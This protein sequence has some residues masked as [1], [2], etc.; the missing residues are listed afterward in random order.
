MFSPTFMYIVIHLA[1]VH[2]STC[3]F[4]FSLRNK[5]NWAPFKSSILNWKQATVGNQQYGAV[6]GC[7]IPN[8]DLCITGFPPMKKCSANFG[9][10]YKLPHGYV[11]DT[12]R[13]KCLLAGSYEFTPSEIEVFHQVE[14]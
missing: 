6:F 11:K 12:I 5:D 3:S 8:P 7:F 2:E 14:S 9:R 10:S 4:I 13:A 1:D